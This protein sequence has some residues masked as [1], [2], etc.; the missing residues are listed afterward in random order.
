MTRTEQK[1]KT[2]AHILTTA[3][4]LFEAD[5]Y[6]A[7]TMRGIAAAAKR[8]TGAVFTHWKDKADL[9]GEVYKDWSPL[10]RVAEALTDLTGGSWHDLSEQGRDITLTALARTHGKI[11]RIIEGK[12]A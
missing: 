4:E 1:A 10:V 8:S 9:H 6:E 7:T 2:R 3:R 12:A 11:R 5:G